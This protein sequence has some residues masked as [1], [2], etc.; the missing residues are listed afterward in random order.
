MTKQA[1]SARQNRQG[2][3]IADLRRRMTALEAEV[4]RLSLLSVEED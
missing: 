1:S 2:S 3:I 4:L